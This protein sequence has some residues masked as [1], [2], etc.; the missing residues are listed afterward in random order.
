MRRLFALDVTQVHPGHD[1]SFDGDLM[2]ELVDS[3]RT[4]LALDPLRK[5]RT[6]PYTPDP[7]AL[8]IGLGTDW[9]GLAAAWLTEWE[10]RGPKAAVARSKL[11]GTMETIGAMPN[12]F[13][14]GS[15]LTTWTP[16]GSRR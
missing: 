14:T 1:E 8:S 3:D 13:V 10:R 12:G 2:R 11:L 5:I 16:A 15:G 4:F 6:E 9:S 7:H